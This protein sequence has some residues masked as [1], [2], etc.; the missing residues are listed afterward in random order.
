MKKFKL[1]TILYSFLTGSILFISIILT[2]N[3]QEH[4][5][6]RDFNEN[7]TGK[8][9]PTDAV[10]INKTKAISNLYQIKYSGIE[11][12]KEEYNL[13][14]D[15]Q[16][17]LI[18]SKLKGL[19]KLQDGNYSFSKNATVPQIQKLEI[20]LNNKL[21]LIEKLTGSSSD[22][23]FEQSSKY[24]Q[25]KIS[26][27]INVFK[28][29]FYDEF[30][31]L[32][33][34]EYNKSP[35][36][37]NLKSIFTI[38]NKEESDYLVKINKSYSSLPLLLN[39][40]LSEV[41][42]EDFSNKFLNEIARLFLGEDNAFSHGFI[43][44]KKYAIYQKEILEEFQKENSYKIPNVVTKK[45]NNLISVK[46]NFAIILARILYYTVVSSILTLLIIRIKKFLFNE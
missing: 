45:L 18:K 8:V 12:A 14:Y 33:Q 42:K 38:I 9:M 20:E 7:P 40:Q 28:Y 19:L 26:M 16:M 11:K 10:E 5:K 1:K 6:Y 36:I 46:N 21:K 17:L 23:I 44:N 24:N 3:Y 29:K 37:L 22:F 2:L 15:M 39:N 13:V 34:L 43:S 35:F 30:D 4:P 27:M 32:I 41:K 31:T 25:D